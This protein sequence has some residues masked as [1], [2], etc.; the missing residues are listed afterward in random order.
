[1]QPTKRGRQGAKATGIEGRRDTGPEATRR[2]GHERQFAIP[3]GCHPTPSTNFGFFGVLWLEYLVLLCL[4]SLTLMGANAITSEGLDHGQGGLGSQGQAAGL[5]RFLA[6]G[7]SGRRVAGVSGVVERRPRRM[8]GQAERPT[9]AL[10]AEVRTTVPGGDR[11]VGSTPPERSLPR[12]AETL[13]APCA[14]RRRPGRLMLGIGQGRTRTGGPRSGVLGPRGARDQRT[15]MR[16][17]PQSSC[18]LAPREIRPVSRTTTWF[19]SA[20]SRPETA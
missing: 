1:M 19:R 4:Y 9:R 7:G 18:R 10:D 6:A 11:L 17:R 12:G 3:A 2:P 5:A 16:E 14:S 15:R 20:P 8:R 13:A